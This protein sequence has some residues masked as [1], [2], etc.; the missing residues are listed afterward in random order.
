MTVNVVSALVP[1]LA[2][3]VIL[4]LMDSFKLVPFR[5]VV[6][7]VLAGGVAALVALALY[8]WLVAAVG[9]SRAS[10]SRY[11]APVVEETLKAIYVVLVLRRRRLGFLVDAAVVGFAVGSGFALAENIDYLRRSHDQR[12]AMSIVR[13]FGPALMHGT[14]TAIFGMLAKTLADRHPDRVMLAVAPAWAAAVAFH[15]VFNHFA[16]PP[17][18]ATCVLLVALPL[19]ITFVFDRSERATREWV[20]EGLDLDIE[21][22]NLVQS[23][24]FGRTR[25]GGYLRDLRARFPGPVVADMFCLLR[26]E[27]EL[28]IRAKG[29]LMAREAGLDVPVDAEVKARLKE[30]NY[31]HRSIGATGLLA[32]KPLRVKSE[33]DDWHRY[34]LEEAGMRTAWWRTLLAARRS[35]R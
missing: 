16:L 9:L 7:A 8:P 20:G 24:D 17:V 35:G 27:L 19:L 15:S 29:M 3:L 2:F 33:R 25:L 34:L 5:A 22:L 30:L 18:V 28:S 1:V 21:L 6:V 23:E 11:V 4:L 26:L 13:G 12:L 31:L 32:L 14:A 10:F